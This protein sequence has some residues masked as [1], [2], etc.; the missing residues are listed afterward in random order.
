MTPM[1]VAELD[2]FKELLQRACG[3]GFTGDRERTLQDGLGQRMALRGAQDP[4]EYLAMLQL[5]PA[6]LDGLVEL[7]TVNETYFLREPEHLNLLVDRL[8]PERLAAHADLVRILCAGCSTGEEPFSVA[9]LL[10]DRADPAAAAR[11][12]LTGVDIDASAVAKARTATYGRYSFRGMDPGF[13]A[14]HFEAAGPLEQRVKEPARGRVAFAVLNLLAPGL[15]PLGLQ[16]LIL[17]R[18]VSIYFP[19]P[20]QQEVFRRL[21]GL[22]K[23]G[24]YLLVGAGET[25]VHDVGILR[26]VE[27]DGLFVFRKDGG[28]DRPERRL[29]RGTPLPRPGPRTATRPAFSPRPAAVAAPVP[30]ATRRRFDDALQ[31]A[32]S[33]R[34]PEA[35]AILDTLLAGDPGHVRAHTLRASVLMALARPREARSACE[36]ALAL[37]PFGSEACLMLGLI[38]RQDG[39][40]PAAL[41]RLREAIYLDASCWLAHYHQ[42][43]L[44]A[45]RGERSRAR[46]G[47]ETALRIL[48]GPGQ[49]TPGQGLFPLSCNAEE[50]ATLCRHKLARLQE[51]RQDDH[52]H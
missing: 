25:L 24:G 45:A 34:E 3:F 40:A 7:L 20:V 17:Y 36:A 19:G 12:A 42:A 23:P 15:P 37:D 48:A 43:E 44:L 21:A 50:F 51:T 22:L 47:Y 14:R 8:V 38:A 27:R 5:E 49:G 4:G 32:R 33:R 52:G 39:D 10:Q 26:L 18:N 35:L 41:N 6:E 2:P 28:I 11:F 46:T 30:G 1:P 29:P 9:M 13:E 16:D 31:C